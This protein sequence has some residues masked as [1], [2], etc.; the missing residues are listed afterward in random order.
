MADLRI[1]RLDSGIT[2]PDHVLVS[3]EIRA[4]DRV[5]DCTLGRAHDALVVERAV[6]REGRVVGVE[7]SLPLFAWT[8]EGLRR[9]DSRIECVHAEARDVLRA[10][11]SASFDCVLFDPMFDRR[12]HHEAGFALVRR[13]A[14]GAPLD[15][16]TLDEAR[17]VARR[18]VVVKAAPQSGR[19]WRLGLTTVPFAKHAQL[20]FGRA[21]G[22]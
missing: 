9:R 5:L 1:H 15:A 17:R 14:A 10:L 12:A 8:Q 11:P 6:G 7:A 13:H 22:H 16:E 18:W 2:Q 21:P 4:A 19:L 3:A 20:R